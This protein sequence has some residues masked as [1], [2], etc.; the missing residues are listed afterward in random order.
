MFKN[1][2]ILPVNNIKYDAG[3][4]SKLGDIELEDR[5]LY[6][7]EF[8]GFQFDKN[9]MASNITE[10]LAKDYIYQQFK[11]DFSYYINE[12]EN[13]KYKKE[14]YSLI[15]NPKYTLHLQLLKFQ[16]IITNMMKTI[17]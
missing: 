4:I 9:Y 7:D 16:E 12:Y 5:F 3:V 1:N 2:L 13:K 14:L 10:L 11:Y 17:F 15:K 8:I 6:H